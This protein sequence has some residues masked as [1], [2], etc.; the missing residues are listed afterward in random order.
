MHNLFFKRVS[1]SFVG[2]QLG[3]ILLRIKELNAA[4]RDEFIAEIT[5]CES[6]GPKPSTLPCEVACYPSKRK[7]IFPG[8]HQTI[9]SRVPTVC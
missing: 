6:A 8:S 1:P 2:E 5:D 4:W 3:R 9:A 7:F